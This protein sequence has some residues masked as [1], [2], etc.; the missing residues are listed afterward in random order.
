MLVATTLFLCACADDGG[1]GRLC[2]DTCHVAP[3]SVRGV[4]ACVPGT[5]VCD[6]EGQ[7][8]ECRGAGVPGPEDCNGVDDDCN[9]MVDER[10]Y[11]APRDDGNDCR[12]CGV[13]RNT[14]K[15]CEQGR[16]V[17]DYPL[18]P[19]PA[20]ERVCDGADE[21]C[22]CRVDEDLYPDPWPCYQGPAGTSV[23]GTCRAG[24][25]ACVDGAEAC[26]GQVLPRSE[27]CNGVDDDC[28]GFVDDVSQEYTGVDMVLGL[29][30]SPSMNGYRLAVTEVVCDYALTAG[31]D[32]RFALLL[33]GE[34]SEGM[35]L[36]QNLAGADV[37]CTALS[38]TTEGGAMEPTLSAAEAVTDP[39]NPLALDWRQSAKR[40]FV[41]FG[42]EHAQATGWDED[43]AVVNTLAYCPESDTIVHWFVSDPWM[44]AE[45][46][47]GC[48]GDVHWLTDQEEFLAQELST[49]IAEICV[50]P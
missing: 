19:P 32:Y 12:Q 49:L 11:L 13:C 27:L 33:I 10:L 35:T 39:T 20:S 28:N 40:V 14:A 18:G 42:D 46:A 41:G 30:V 21:D 25:W 24:L 7:V 38:E 43:E 16:W 36:V 34:P 9:G 22:D 29:D 6:E 17:C 50:A 31:D 8:L 23:L 47:L 3:E 2:P 15:V 26:D 44:H 4:G 1:L 37:V 5:P 48:G 45:Q